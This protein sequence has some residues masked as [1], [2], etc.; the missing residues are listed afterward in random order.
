MDNSQAFLLIIMSFFWLL[1]G[2]AGSNLAK[3]KNRNQS[4]WFINCI[5]TGLF[6]VL[7]IACST[8]LEYDEDLDYKETDTLGWIVL[9]LGLVMFGFT[10]WNIYMQVKAYYNNLWWNSYFQMMR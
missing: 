10:A 8:S 2:I 7:V 4:L 6:G 9:V 5:L 1:M 3:K